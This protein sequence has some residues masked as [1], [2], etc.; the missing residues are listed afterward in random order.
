MTETILVTGAAGHLGRA[1]LRHL[2]ESRKFPA[3]SLIAT[4]R[5]PARLADLAARGV[6]VRAMDFNDAASLPVAFEGADRALIISTDQL[7]IGGTGRLKQHEAAIAAA[8]KA[9]VAHLA[10][11][12]MPNPEPG[13]PILFAGD[14]YGSEQALKASGLAYTIFRNG[15]YQENLLPSLPQALAAGRWVTSAGDGRIAHGARDDYAAA[16]AGGL[17]SSPAESAT[18]TLTGP[19]AYTVAEIAALVSEVTGKPLEVVQVSDEA[20][21]EGLKAH[22]LPDPVARLIASFDANTRAGRIALVTDAVETLSGRKP[23]TLRSFLEA[24]RAALAA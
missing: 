15:W 12:S 18:Y 20:L 21:A 16:I 22:G 3:A 17:A 10:Y 7:D 9:G 23:A 19:Q 24:N 14:H 6:A 5:D 13:S 4:S 8:K 11:T 2:L 1:V